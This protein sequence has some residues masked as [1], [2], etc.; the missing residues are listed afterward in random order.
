MMRREF[1]VN[2][3]A[4]ILYYSGIISLFNLIEKTKKTRKV[5]IL[6]YHSI[7]DFKKE[8]FLY[9]R[10]VISSSPK[11]FEKQI[12]YL[13][14]KFHIISLSEYTKMIKNKG[15]IPRNSVI[16]TFDDGYKNNYTN[17]YPILSKYKV[18]ATIFLTSGKIGT[19]KS[20][21]WDQIAWLIQKTDVLKINLDS[22]GKYNLDKP[23]LKIKATD[24]ILDRLK[25]MHETEKD[26]TID[27]LVKKLRIKNHNE[28]FN[29]IFLSWDEV[30][31]M[32]KDCITFGAHTVSHPNLAN[33]SDEQI[34]RELLESK[35]KIEVESGKPVNSFA[36]PYG[37]FEHFNERIKV[38]VQDAGF[39][40]AC[41]TIYERQNLSSD[42]YQLRRIPIFHYHN[43]NVFK[44]KLSG[45][46]DHFN[47]LEKSCFKS[48][49]GKRGSIRKLKN[50]V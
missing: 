40:C 19:L 20:F 49:S 15:K 18:P 44:T 21:W 16:I 41:S 22:L 47:K 3:I 39:T 1:F 25:Q 30:R 17:A 14:K 43:M 35:H 33:I 9:Y 4:T 36:Y 5:T 28:T 24:R 2:F 50:S 45:I 29:D 38:M 34:K 10:K 27:K 42:P 7:C 37:R 48:R 26:I 31:E 8:G 11:N 6:L 12:R 32:S 13:E 46:F 23:A